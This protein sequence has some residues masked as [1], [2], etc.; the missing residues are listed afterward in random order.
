MHII[1]RKRTFESVLEFTQRFKKFYHKIPAEVK[2]S[3]P[4]AKVTFTGDFEPDFSLILRERRYVDLTRMQDDAIEIDS[5]MMELGKLKETVK[6]GTKETKRFREHVGTS[7][8]GRSSEEK[9]DYMAKII[10]DLSNKISRM[11]LDQAKPDP[12]SRRYF[13]RNP[14]PQIQQRLVKNEDQKIKAPFKTEKF[15]Q[16]DDMQDY[17]GLDEDRNNLSDDDIEPHLTR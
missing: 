5:N 2:P 13:K 12:F 9:M 7:G 16:S 4:T 11:E 14:N 17:D 10:K 6:I 8:S 3:Q 1:Q 15:M